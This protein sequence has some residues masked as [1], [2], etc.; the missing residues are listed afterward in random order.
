[1]WQRNRQSHVDILTTANSARFNRVFT[2]NG[3]SVLPLTVSAANNGHSLAIKLNYA[4]DSAAVFFAGGPL[5]GRYI[6]DNIH[7]H[8]GAN[9]DN[10]GSEH[11][12]DGRKSATEA[13]VVS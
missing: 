1:M 6:V 3:L 9:N 2:I 8:W 7:W 13:H 10:D 11:A 12:M 4:N 5:H